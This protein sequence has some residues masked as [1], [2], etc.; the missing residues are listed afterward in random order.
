MPTSCTAG[1]LRAIRTPYILTILIH[2]LSV[3]RA[4]YYTHLMV[5]LISSRYQMNASRSPL[6]LALASPSP[7]DLALASR[8][9]LNYQALASCSPLNN[10]H[11][12]LFWITPGSPLMERLDQGHINPQLEHPSQTCPR[13]GL[14]CRPPE[15]Q[16]GTLAKSYSNSLHI[17]LFWCTDS[18]S[19]LILVWSGRETFKAYSHCYKGQKFCAASYRTVCFLSSICSECILCGSSC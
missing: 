10:R 17:W 9:P 5:L 3:W 7:L 4:H 2:C 8:S 1:G 14:N 12:P 13:W 6:D 19:H 16:A 15:L 11:V 18:A